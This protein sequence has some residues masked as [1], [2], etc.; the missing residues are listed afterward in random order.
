M[1]NA[2][3]PIPLY[4]LQDASKKKNSN[5]QPSRQQPEAQLFEYNIETR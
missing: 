4:L 5:Q 1:I 3:I 2:A